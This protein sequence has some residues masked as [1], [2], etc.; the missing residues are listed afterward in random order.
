LS[1]ISGG[2]CTLEV[3]KKLL[4]INKDIF[5]FIFIVIGFFI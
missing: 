2:D 1:Y 5:I 4:V 3:V